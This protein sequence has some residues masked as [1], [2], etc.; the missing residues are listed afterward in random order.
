MCRVFFF[1]FFDKTFSSLAGCF[2]VSGVFLSVSACWWWTQGVSW[3]PP[4]CC[5]ASLWWWDADG[6]FEPLHRW[7][8]RPSTT[9]PPPY[10]TTWG[11]A[12]LSWASLVKKRWL[13]PPTPG[14]HA[15][16]LTC[17]HRSCRRAPPAACFQHALLS[18]SLAESLSHT[19]NMRPKRKI[20]CTRLSLC[21]LLPLYFLSSAAPFIAE[22][23]RAWRADGPV[24]V[25]AEAAMG[26]EIISFILSF[27]GG[28]RQRTETSR[29]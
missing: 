27:I 29:H 20:K 23:S 15:H 11:R 25:D 8:A 10:S 13:R 16:G 19:Q 21:L 6:A 18:V 7:W 28:S 1:L 3:S 22:T 26:V 14:M 4:L 5:V 24:M 12:E 17:A 9:N 2:L